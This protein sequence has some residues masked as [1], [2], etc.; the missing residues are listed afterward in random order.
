MKPII[1]FIFVIFSLKQT[2]ATQININNCNTSS[3]TI[4]FKNYNN[5]YKLSLEDKSKHFRVEV[6]KRYGDM[7]L[8][9]YYNYLFVQSLI[10]KYGRAISY[11]IIRY[12]LTNEKYIILYFS[13]DVLNIKF[14]NLLYRSLLSNYISYL[15][16]SI[17]II[18]NTYKD[19]QGKTCYGMMIPIATDKLVTFITNSKEIQKITPLAIDTWINYCDHKFQDYH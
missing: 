1:F 13:N 3:D 18:P 2:S 14:K 9:E 8:L 17:L 15:R 12:I 7:S 19:L 4:I 16:K 6:N 10:K 11:F 5:H